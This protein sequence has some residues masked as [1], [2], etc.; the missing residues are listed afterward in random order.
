[1]HG[2]ADRLTSAP[3][4][5]EFAAQAGERCTLRIWEGFYHEIHNEPEQEQVFAFLS[6][7]LESRI[8]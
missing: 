3:A 8:E 7:W 6:D 1:M 4:S 5:R 2:A